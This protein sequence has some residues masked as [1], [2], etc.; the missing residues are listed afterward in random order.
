MGAIVNTTEPMSRIRVVTSKDRAADTLKL[1]QRA[2]VLHAEESTELKPIDREAVEKERRQVSELLATIEDV[3]KYV[4]TERL[5]RVQQDVDVFLTRPLDDIDKDT[6]TLCTRLGAMHQRLE[7]LRQEQETLEE[8]RTVAAALASR[9]DLTTA[10]LDFTGA[11][12]FSR[13]VAVPQ[14]IHHAVGQ[15]LEP[16]TLSRVVIDRSELAYVF[17]VAKADARPAIERWA[18]DNTGRFITPPEKNIPLE[19]FVG[20]ADKESA[21]LQSEAA[22]IHTDIETQTEEN[23]EL[24]VLLREALFAENERLE[25]LEKAC[26]AKYVTL[27]EGWM[28]SSGVEAVTG[29]LRETIGY[30]YVESRPVRPE[31]EPP[32]KLRNVKPLRPFEV[33]VNLFGTPKYRE[34]D[35]T[36]I[37]AYS[38]AFFFGVMLG[39]AVYGI[40]LMLLTKFALPKL[41]DDPQSDGFALFKSLLYISAG[42]AIV[43]GAL[44]G[45]YL[46]DFFPRFFGAPNLALAPAIQEVYLDTM[47]F[48]V[49]ALVIGLIHVNIG[50]VLMFI[51]GFKERQ[52]H[53]I[54]G[55]LGL[56]ILQIAGIPWIMNF[57]GVE[58]LPLAQA[59]YTILL[60]TMLGSIVLIIVASVMEKGTFLGSIFW[61]FDITGILGDVMSY[62]RLAGVG[63][64]TYF[65]AYCFNMLSVLV[66]DMLPAGIIRLVLGSIIMLFI[67]LFGHIL[68]LV[69]SSITCFVH[70]L[71]LCFVEFLFKFYEGG[72]R[73]YSPLRLRR[74][75]LVPLK[76]KA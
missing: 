22:E 24:L 31:E 61:V 51:R 21:R 69:L 2:G 34:W 74:R 15:Q 41:V 4:P 54:I 63:L 43:I 62:A 75:N 44:T 27:F 38:F 28:P 39:D 40:F 72:G 50:H 53:L 42:S 55:R 32:S 45:T 76:A 16:L 29:D 48:I 10:D 67:L 68:N 35:P 73:P 25:V 58:L 11:H 37:I 70:S 5:V 57:I 33:V 1:L 18:G 36:P 8:L 60:Y 49:V 23:L 19:D 66:A 7:K 3:L 59:T 26:E 17:F 56:F 46:G 12:L 65:L 13:I 9:T 14:E 71:R 52:H 64:A 47:T 20:Y 30:V 6:R